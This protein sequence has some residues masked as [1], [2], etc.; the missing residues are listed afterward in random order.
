MFSQSR[1]TFSVLMITF[2][3]F[4]GN[5]SADKDSEESLK[6]FLK[7]L[8]SSLRDGSSLHADGMARAF[9][10][11]ISGGGSGPDTAAIDEAIRIVENI[12][13]SGDTNKNIV[14]TLEK[15][16]NIR[17]VVKIRQQRNGSSAN[18]NAEVN[19]ERVGVENERSL[20]Q[21]KESEAALTDR[22]FHNKNCFK[23]GQICGFYRDSCCARDTE[24]GSNAFLCCIRLSGGENFLLSDRYGYC[25]P[26]YASYTCDEMERMY[27]LWQR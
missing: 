19:R 10:G 26:S 15:L 27:S 24:Y 13:A 21:G 12:L 2:M 16:I 20:S 8:T 25:V 14:E 1:S 22:D 3:L 17:D 6:S 11:S 9:S 4:G 7:S 18:R 5:L 23:L